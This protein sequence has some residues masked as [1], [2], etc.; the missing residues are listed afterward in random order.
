M[1]Y[2]SKGEYEGNRRRRIQDKDERRR[3]RRRRKGR[4]SVG[5]MRRIDD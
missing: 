5:R 2:V 3:G 1:K 4:M